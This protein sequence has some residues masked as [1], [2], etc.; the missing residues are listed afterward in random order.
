MCVMLGCAGWCD[1]Q[2]TQIKHNNKSNVLVWLRHVVRLTP[3]WRLGNG[4]QSGP[5]VFQVDQ[6]VGQRASV[7][8][9]P[10]SYVCP[11]VINQQRFRTNLH[12]LE[13]VQVLGNVAFCPWIFYLLCNVDSA[14]YFTIWFVFDKNTFKYW[15]PVWLCVS[16]GAVILSTHINSS[17]SWSTG[18]TMERWIHIM[19]C[20]YGHL[21][22]SLYI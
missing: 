7:S 18:Y 13:A 1:Q 11:S 3:G 21:I 12:L 4:G 19:H 15:H 5:P 9:S 22:K 10:W 14:S 16:C 2:E 8:P 6:Q 20:R 17:Q